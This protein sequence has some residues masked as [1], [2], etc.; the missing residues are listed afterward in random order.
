MDKIGSNSKSEYEL[1]LA[2][3]L[4]SAVL[5]GFLPI[6]W[7]ALRPIDSYVIILYRILLVAVVCFVVDLKIYGI[8]KIIEPMK[9][10]GVLL[11]YLAVGFLITFN[12]SLYIWAVNADFVI[13]TCIGY[14]IEP[15]VVCIF[16]I[17]FF[18]EKISR[19]KMIALIFACA[20]IVI[21]LLHFGELPLIAIGLST[22]FAA[23][24]AIKKS[25]RIEAMLS[26]FY[27]TIFL[28]PP[29]LIAII[30]LEI[31][32]KGAL[33]AGESYQYGLLLLCGIMT[34]TPLGL[35]AASANRLPLI[36]LG[37]IEYVSPT[38]TLILGI[39][40][41]REPFDIVQLMAFVVI[42]IG[43][44]FFTYGE[45]KAVKSLGTEKQPE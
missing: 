12:W 23:Y 42:W 6:Y 25:F 14:Y 29:A 15:L 40:L 32:N 28:A 2:A 20:G 11:R 19:Y 24:A 21:L 44:L 5:W 35:F 4:G 27:E 30:Y 41:F 7:Q 16:G 10:K 38:I 31:N 45:I 18:S 39:F 22:T 33:G 36:T 17:V 8:R 13:Q 43:L 9:Q 3:C 26:L 34:A 37:L 1:G